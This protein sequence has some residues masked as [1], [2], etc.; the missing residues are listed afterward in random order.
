MGYTGKQ[1]IH[2]GQVPVVQA[3]FLPSDKQIE[4]ASG[5]LKAFE[6]HQNQGKVCII[7]LFD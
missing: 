7:N 2:P 1:V 6:E 3:S 4:W 5:L